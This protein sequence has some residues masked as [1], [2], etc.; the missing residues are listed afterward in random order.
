MKNLQRKKHTNKKNIAERR[1]WNCVN[2]K[3]NEKPTI[4]QENKKEI[5]IKIVF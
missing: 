2:D 3:F 5:F 1:L 4:K